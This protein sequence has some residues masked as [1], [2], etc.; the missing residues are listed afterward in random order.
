MNIM[1][2]LKYSTLPPD[3][4]VLVKQMTYTVHVPE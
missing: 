1:N 2:E 3:N 4:C